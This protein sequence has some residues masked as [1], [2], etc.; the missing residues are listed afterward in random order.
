MKS[1]RVTFCGKQILLDGKHLA[2]ARDPRAAGV[3]TLMLNRGLLPCSV[4]D[5]EFE[6]YMELF[7]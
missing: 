4:S 6:K 3:I 1:R 7:A 2:D 5:A